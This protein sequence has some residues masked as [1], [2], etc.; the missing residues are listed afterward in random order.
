M[1]LDPTDPE[2]CMREMAEDAAERLARVLRSNPEAITSLDERKIKGLWH[3]CER[4][5]SAEIVLPIL[6]SWSVAPA[7]REAA[8]E[9]R[10]YVNYGDILEVFRRH[11][12]PLGLW[13]EEEP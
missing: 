6:L 5:D 13:P 8:R 3:Q 2:A 4:E 9:S 1:T 7:I 10:E 12:A 11:L